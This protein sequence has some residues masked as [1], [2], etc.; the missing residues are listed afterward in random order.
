LAHVFRVSICGWVAGS[1]AFRLV[2]RKN[3]MTEG[4]GREK[5]VHLIAARK[6][7]ETERGQGQDPLQRHTPIYL[8]P[9]RPTFS[10]L[11]IMLSNYESINGPMY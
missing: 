1:I 2:A 9:V 11:P 4:H 6:P 5:T 3:I 10:Y 7:R 8:F